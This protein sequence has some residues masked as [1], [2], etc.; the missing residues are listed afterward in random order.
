MYLRNGT[1]KQH[2]AANRRT[3]DPRAECWI[4]CPVQ[5]TRAALLWEARGMKWLIAVLACVAMGAGVI[6]T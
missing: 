6:F 5:G 4:G 1:Y 2:R 3:G